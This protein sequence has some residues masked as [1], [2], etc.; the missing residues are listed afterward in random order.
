MFGSVTLKA[1]KAFQK[2][3]NIVKPRQSGYGVVGKK[4]RVMLNGMR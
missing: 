1:V 4:T 3:Y 2:Q